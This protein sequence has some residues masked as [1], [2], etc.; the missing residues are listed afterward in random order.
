MRPLR[1]FTRLAAQSDVYALV[2]LYGNRAWTHVNDMHVH[3]A[4]QLLLI[5]RSQGTC[6][7]VTQQ[8]IVIPVSLHGIVT[9][10]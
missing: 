4:R 7:D 2:I 10:N 1:F 8:L 9:L 3:S 5:Y 6:C